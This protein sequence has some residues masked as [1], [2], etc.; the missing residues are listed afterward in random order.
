[1]DELIPGP[2]LPGRVHVVCSEIPPDVVGGLGRYAERMMDALRGG[3]VPVTV[4]GTARRGRSPRIERRGDVTLHR[5]ATA[6]SDHARNSRT[7]QV[8]RRAAKIAGLLAFNV[9]VAGRIL[10]A[11][12]GRSRAARSGHGRSGTEQSGAGRSGAGRS[13]TGRSGAVVAVHDWMGAPAGILCRLLGRLPV[14]F[15]VHTRELN[16]APS[17]A[18]SLLAACLDAVETAQARL[19]DL[20]IVPSA[21]VREDLA[22][23]GWPGERLRVLPHGFEEPELLRLAAL[24]GDERAHVASRV[25]SRYLPGGEGRLVVF[26]GRLSPHK[27][28]HTL[29]RAVPR[30]VRRYGD[31]R[32]VIIGA[33][34]PQTDDNAVVARLIEEAGVGGHVVAEYRFLDPAEL[35]AHFLAADVCVFPSVYEPFGLVAVEAMALARPVLV[36]PG[37]S[38]EVVGDGALRCARDC[39]EELSAALSRCLDD[40]AEAARLAARG[41]AYVRERY[42]WFRTA[43]QTLAAYA[44]A[45]RRPPGA[46]AAR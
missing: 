27:G 35:F 3:G 24:P 2:G 45:A 13:G 18:R 30:L 10:R 33:Q 32:V 21:G 38:P 42:S 41:A 31:L 37:Y 28:V 25:R 12:A 16:A 36:G 11:E 43:E 9:R 26:A 39:P 17:G 19:A 46:G 34:L 44:E 7:P 8:L 6:S 14:V 40:P 29:I 22:A 23:R 1:M 5:L 20:I 15:H 4:Y